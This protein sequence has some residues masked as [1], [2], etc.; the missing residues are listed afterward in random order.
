MIRM[1]IHVC[2]FTSVSSR[3]PNPKAA[4][5]C[6]VAD[7]HVCMLLIMKEIQVHHQRLPYTHVRIKLHQHEVH[8]SFTPRLEDA[9]HVCLMK[10]KHI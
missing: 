4:I 7:I 8:P 10:L 5:V 3:P 9:I 1:L 2:F 6:P